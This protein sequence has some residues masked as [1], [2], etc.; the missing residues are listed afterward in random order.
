[1]IMLASHLRYSGSYDAG[2]LPGVI[3]WVV[4][5]KDGKTGLYSIP[6][7][8]IAAFVFYYP[9]FTDIFVNYTDRQGGEPA[10]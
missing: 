3:S 1:M 7:N 6:L 4:P 2:S 8:D 10:L 9:E 5:S